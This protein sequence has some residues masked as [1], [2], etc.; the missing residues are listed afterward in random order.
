MAIIRKS[1]RFVLT[2]RTTPDVNV[3]VDHDGSVTMRQESGDDRSGS[4]RT[5]TV[6]LSAEAAAEL[7]DALKA[8]R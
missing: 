7:A 3:D 4:Y 1:T 5:E 6:R 2:S 8:D